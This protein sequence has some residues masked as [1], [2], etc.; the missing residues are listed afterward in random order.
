IDEIAYGPKGK[1]LDLVVE[2]RRDEFVQQVADIIDRTFPVC[3]EALK[4][5]GL[6]IDHV[7]DVILVGG[8]TKIPYVRDQVARFFATAPR[9]DVNPEDAVA[10][11]AA[12]QANALERLL[13]RPSGSGQVTVPAFDK[14][15]GTFGG[16]T[17]GAE[18][19]TYG[20]TVTE[21]DDAPKNPS[22]PGE[23]VMK[24]GA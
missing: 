18:T 15:E 1:A 20:E 17:T 23:Y 14:S 11:G 8:T 6:T 19:A 3:E 5:A 16:E 21:V 12:L 7:D 9:T 22:R 10:L 2:I 24:R 4:L 13:A